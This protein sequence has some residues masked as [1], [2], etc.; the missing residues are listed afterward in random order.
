MTHD[1]MIRL[2]HLLDEL[3]HL[4]WMGVEALCA[5]CG[6]DRRTLSRDLRLLRELGLTIER[7]DN[8]LHM[9]ASSLAVLRRVM[10]ESTIPGWA[11]PV[12]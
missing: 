3:S 11:A 7:R 1:R 10:L 9:P 2:L 4:E 12:L 6:I 5:D 8:Q